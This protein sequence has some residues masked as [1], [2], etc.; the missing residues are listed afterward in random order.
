MIL[1]VLQWPNQPV[2]F[3][4][5]SAHQG[6]VFINVGILVL[7][8]QIPTQRSSPGYTTLCASL[9]GPCV[10]NKGP[11]QQLDYL[12]SPKQTS[13]PSDGPPLRF[14]TIILIQIT[15]INL[16]NI[17]GLKENGQKQSKSLSNVTTCNVFLTK[18]GQNGQNQIFPGTFN[19]FFQK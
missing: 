7:N 3:T 1:Q 10:Y 9:Y 13:T 14:K 12:P 8:G 16:K 17:N 5:G 15:K 6:P 18:K 11:V 4:E 2:K 19:C